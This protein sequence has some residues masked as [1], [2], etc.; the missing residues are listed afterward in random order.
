VWCICT[1][2]VFCN[3]QSLPNIMIFI[4]DWNYFSTTRELVYKTPAFHVPR[5]SGKLQSSFYGGKGQGREAE[6][7]IK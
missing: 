7:C 5:C 4:T 6:H 3:T 1:G 2:M